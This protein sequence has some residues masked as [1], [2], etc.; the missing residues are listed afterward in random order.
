[1]SI[2]KTKTIFIQ[3]A[4]ELVDL[5]DKDYFY[6]QL[7]TPFLLERACP[8]EGVPPVSNSLPKCTFH[9]Y[10]DKALKFVG[11]IVVR[12]SSKPSLFFPIWSDI[13]DPIRFCL[14]LKSIKLDKTLDAIYQK[15]KEELIA[16]K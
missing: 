15:K 10:I 11:N 12:G 8:K 6:H 4:L 1:M 13:F 2:D 14:D 3:D 16:K 9:S 7:Y 5:N